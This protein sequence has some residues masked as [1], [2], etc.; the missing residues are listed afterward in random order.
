MLLPHPQKESA[1][2]TG[3]VDGE[4][5]LLGSQLDRGLRDRH[6]KADNELGLLQRLGLGEGLR[7]ALHSR[8]RRR[9]EGTLRSCKGRKQVAEGRCDR[10]GIGGALIDDLDRRL[11]Q[12]AAVM[13]IERL[14]RDGVQLRLLSGGRRGEGL[15]PEHPAAE[16]AEGVDA[17]VVRFGLHRVS[18]IVALHGKI[19]GQK[20]ALRRHRV[21]K[22]AAQKRD[23]IGQQRL[24]EKGVVQK[25]GVQPGELRFAALADDR[26]AGRAVGRL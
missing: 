11:R 8:R 14:R 26:A 16:P 5:N 17:L 22:L 12:D 2:G 20:A 23:H 1:A 25:F 21:Q 18:Q 24:R 10:A 13:G 19:F 6:A 15:A 7:L 4:K 3:A 9:R